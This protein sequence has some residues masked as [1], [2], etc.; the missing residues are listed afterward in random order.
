MKSVKFEFLNKHIFVI[1]GSGQGPRRCGTGLAEAW[2]DGKGRKKTGRWQW[3]CQG[4]EKKTKKQM[5]LINSILSHV[6]CL[7]SS[8][9]CFLSPTSCLTSLVS[10]LQSQISCLLSHVPCLRCAAI[11][12]NILNCLATISFYLLKFL[13]FLIITPGDFN[14]PRSCFYEI[15]M[16][17]LVRKW[18]GNGTN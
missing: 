16:L 15:F 13:L 5:T 17:N 7:M 1:Q 11:C 8:V 14:H 9:S 6:S 10:D 3:R 4:E 2:D 12:P 18:C